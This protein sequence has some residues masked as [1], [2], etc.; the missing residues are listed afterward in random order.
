M[1]KVVS[2]VAKGW[3]KVVGG[4]EEGEQGGR[5]RGAGGRGEGGGGGG[6]EATWSWEV[7]K[8]LLRIAQICFFRKNCSVNVKITHTQIEFLAGLKEAASC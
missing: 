7:R 1:N 4:S 8:T 6:G 2:F 3:E 5:R